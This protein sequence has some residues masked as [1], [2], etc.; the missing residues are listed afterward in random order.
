MG[1]SHDHYILSTTTVTLV[2]S[3]DEGAG[4]PRELK[5]TSQGHV[6]LSNRLRK[7]NV[8]RVCLEA[9]D[10]YH[11]DLALALDDVGLE[12][13][14]IHPKAAKRFAEAIQTCTKTDAV[15]AALLTEFAH[16]MPFEPWQRPD[17][18]A[19]P[20]RACARRIAALNKLR[21]QTKNQLHAAQLTATTPDFLIADLQ[22]SITQLDAQIESLRQRARD[23]IAT[24]EQL[25]H[26]CDLL[27][28]VTGIADTSA[29]QLIGELLVLPDD[30]QA[31]QWVAI[32]AM[33]KNRTPF[34]SRRFYSPLET[35]A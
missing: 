16:C 20:I 21:T 9:T 8:S 18:L 7:A 25:Q 17:D 28:S 26:A 34:D 24:D 6:T 2:I 10:L 5:N 11:L 14:V 23:L 12:V 13:M 29:I 33:L 32:H 3:R 35:T 19:L 31:K 1:S 4:N 27:I 30:R 15:D 22:Q